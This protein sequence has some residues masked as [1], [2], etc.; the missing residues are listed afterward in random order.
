MLG[1]F[2]R[3][4]REP[5]VSEIERSDLQECADIHA[6]SFANPWGDGEIAAMLKKNRIKGLVARARQGRTRP[7][8]GFVLYRMAGGEAEVI[9]IATAPNS[10]R[11]GT[12]RVLMNEMIRQCL[13]ERLDEIFLE[14][15]ENNIAAIALYKSLA[16]KTVGSRPGYYQNPGETGTDNKTARSNALI[17]RLDLGD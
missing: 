12:G 6:G 16:F 3:K 8:E 17:M 11:K 1:F 2:S 15:D 5:F 9:T 10:R 4:P 7:L 13:T 14:V